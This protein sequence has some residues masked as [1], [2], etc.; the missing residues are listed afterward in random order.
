[1]SSFSRE[2]RI[3]NI[4]AWGLCT[5]THVCTHVHMCT[6]AHTH[7]PTPNLGISLTS[8]GIALLHL[9]YALTTR[10]I[11]CITEL[12]ILPFT[13]IMLLGASSCLG[14]LYSRT[15]VIINFTYINKKYTDQEAGTQNQPSRFILSSM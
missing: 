8:I 11:D 13:E 15:S 9:L 12:C 7:A 5:H 10:G 14:S 2:Q 6:H 1:M 4:R 3:T